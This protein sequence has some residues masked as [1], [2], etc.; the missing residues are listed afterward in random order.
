MSLESFENSASGCAELVVKDVTKG[1]KLR[2]EIEEEILVSSA[3]AGEGENATKAESKI[4]ELEELQ[5][6][7]IRDLEQ[8]LHSTQQILQ[9]KEEELQAITTQY[10][11]T[12][13]ELL[14]SQRQFST[15]QIQHAELQ[16]TVAGYS[17]LL[18]Q[19]DDEIQETK[20]QVK[21]KNKTQHF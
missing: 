20:E 13:D 3:L 21:G 6:N 1:R 7:R 9:T 4:T 2:E 10:R 5:C 15:L 12:N 14:H 11:A 8:Q 16:Q 17:E 18:L 19:A